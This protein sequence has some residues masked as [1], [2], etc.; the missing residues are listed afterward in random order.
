MSVLY[1]LLPFIL[2]V[3]LSVAAYGQDTLYYYKV[4]EADKACSEE[5]WDDA[6]RILQE[7]MQVD[8]EN[9]GN[10]LLMSNLGMVQH[11]MGEDSLALA[12]LTEAHR[13]AP[14]SVTILSNRAAILLEC[15]FD[16]EAYEDYSLV[17]ELDSADLNARLRHGMIALR[18][19]DIRTARDDFRFLEKNFPSSREARIGMSTLHCALGQYREAIPYYNELIDE[20]PDAEFYTGRALCHLMCDNLQ[21]AS[22]DIAEGL[23]LNP[24]DGELYLYRAALNRMRYRPDDAEADARRAVALGVD[25]ARAKQFFR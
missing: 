25:P 15:G 1:R 6:A 9:T 2:T 12:T 18:A 10:L 4:E 16:G 3:V 20:T 13:R 7:A 5:R 11:M 21:E 17:L 8:P 14:A 24:D 22:D 19:R 23:H